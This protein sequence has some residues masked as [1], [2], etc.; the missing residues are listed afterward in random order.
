MLV[1]FSI[2]Q[3]SKTFVHPVSTHLKL[4]AGMSEC[5]YIKKNLWSW[6]S[7]SLNILFIFSFKYCICHEGLHMFLTALKS[8]YLWRQQLHKGS[9][10]PVQFFLA[11]SHCRCFS[12]KCQHI[13]LHHCDG[14]Q[15]G[16][17]GDWIEGCHP[18]GVSL[19]RA[20]THCPYSMWA[21]RYTLH[22][23]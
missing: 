12:K 7:K 22:L 14:Q 1:F 21:E 18:A 3:H 20:D 13:P 9:L 15:C 6:W 8:T 17:Y 4:V 10:L 23:C 2:S 5:A 16:F 19:P 11:S